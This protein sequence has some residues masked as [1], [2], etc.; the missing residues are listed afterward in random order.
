MNCAHNTFGWE[1]VTH[2]LFFIHIYTYVGLGFGLHID[3][4]TL[5]YYACHYNEYFQ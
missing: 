2:K 4:R 3:I 1:V 5:Y